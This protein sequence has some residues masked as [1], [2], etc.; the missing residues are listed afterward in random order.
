[1]ACRYWVEQLARD[2]ETAHIQRREELL[3]R[4]LDNFLNHQA[5]E[6]VPNKN[7]WFYKVTSQ[8]DSSN[9]SMEDKF[10]TGQYR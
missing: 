9:H 2:Q 4:E 5:F 3:Q 10:R 6:K 1:M 8:E 7:K